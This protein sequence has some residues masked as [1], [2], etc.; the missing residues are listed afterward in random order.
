VDQ[1]ET[2]AMT[3]NKRPERV[4]F[5]CV[6]NCNRSQMAEAFARMIGEGQVEAYSAGCHPAECVHPKAIA[7][8]KQLGY[9]MRQHFPKGLSAVSN[10]EF[11]VAVTMGCEDQRLILNAK[12]REDWNIPCPKAMPPEQ[13]QVVRDEIKEKVRDLLA[14]L[15][16]MVEGEPPNTAIKRRVVVIR[17]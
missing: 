9:D 6:E 8:M 11:D 15:P 5:V 1:K 2:V 13:F 10:I 12:H 7:A 16:T 17:E 4:L 14:R 3:H